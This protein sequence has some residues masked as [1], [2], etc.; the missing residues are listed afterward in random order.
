MEGDFLG[1]LIGY[2]CLG[3][4]AGLLSGLFGIGG[5]LIIVPSLVWLY[6]MQG[7]QVE[8]VVLMAI[9]TSLATIIVT[10]LSSVY[11]HHSRHNA[12][13][14]DVVWKLVPGLL[15]GA[16]LGTM[17]ADSLPTDVL[18]SIFAI[19]LIGVTLRMWKENNTQ[20]HSKTKPKKPFFLVGSIIGTL[21]TI[22]GI[23]GGTLTVPYLV[24]NRIAM[25]NAVAI[26]SACGLPIAI[27]GTLGYTVLG[28]NNSN[29]PEPS[30]GY[31][32]LPAFIG[33]IS[34]SLFCAPLGA[35]LAHSV[36]STKLKRIF[37]VLVC[38]IG[39]KLI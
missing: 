25:G 31:I 35:K 10:S 34:T 7:I 14:W 8:R 12:V 6:T 26:S 9:A 24:K 23:G 39:I 4:V 20:D 36:P 17:V 21:S 13:L 16:V 30:M 27:F 38:I 15:I 2:F 32:Y 5:G 37:A 19:Y 1:Y 3:A 29:L 33:I 28:W 22:L 11:A 18:R